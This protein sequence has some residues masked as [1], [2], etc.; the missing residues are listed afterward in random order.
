MIFIY[1][2]IGVLFIIN[3]ITLFVLINLKKDYKESLDV[4]KLVVE[5][6]KQNN[7]QLDRIYNIHTD[8]Y[9]NYKNIIGQYELIKDIH[10]KIYEEY[11]FLKEQY[12]KLLSNNS[13]LTENI[14]LV[15][16]RYSDCYEQFV[17]INGK[18]DSTTTNN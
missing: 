18:L 11:K 16:E 1:F 14:K 6:W 17:M 5:L 10:E 4:N 13:E 15:E 2:L 9:D 12:N 3:I 8:I 7:S